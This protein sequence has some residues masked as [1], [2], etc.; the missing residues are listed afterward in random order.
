MLSASPEPGEPASASLMDDSDVMSLET[1]SQEKAAGGPETP[2]TPLRR[3]LALE[4]EGYE[5]QESD[6][7]LETSMSDTS[8]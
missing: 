4:C 6:M 1:P 5:G 7:M 3:C 8:T 2:E